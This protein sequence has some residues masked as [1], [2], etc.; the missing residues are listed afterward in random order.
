MVEL[1]FHTQEV[2]LER[3]GSKPKGNMVDGDGM[4]TLALC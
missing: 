2:L 3:F 1:L 4:I